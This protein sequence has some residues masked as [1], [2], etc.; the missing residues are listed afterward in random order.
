M[1]RSKHRHTMRAKAMTFSDM[2]LGK[3]NEGAVEFHN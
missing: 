1:S 3:V 2:G